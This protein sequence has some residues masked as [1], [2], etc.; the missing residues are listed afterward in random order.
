MTVRVALDIRGIPGVRA[1]LRAVKTGP[2]NRVLKAAARKA[3]TATKPDLKG[4]L[5]QKKVNRTGLYSRSIS[6]LYKGYASGNWVVMLGGQ[7]GVVGMHAAAV[8]GGG[9]AS[10]GDLR[11]GGRLDPAKYAHL[12]EGGRRSLSAGMLRGAK[13]F[14]MIVRRLSAVRR[15]NPAARARKV[16]RGHL[17]VG[18]TGRNGQLKMQKG[19]KVPGGWLIFARSARAAGHKRP[20]EETAPAFKS[21]LET[22]I[23]HD[24]Q[25]SLAS[26]TANHP[27]T[28]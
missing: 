14:P 1:A 22:T 12:V 23:Y 26:L 13:A 24:V 19:K 8:A 27:R 9:L 20:V 21:R 2:L 7:H 6:T 18:V 25:V 17:Q 28:P 5:R 15:T 16:D 10:H 4:K 3:A 11:R